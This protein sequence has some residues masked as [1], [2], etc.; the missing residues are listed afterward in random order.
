MPC[1]S[2]APTFEEVVLYA[3]KQKLIGKVDIRK[4]YDFYDRSDFLYRGIPMDWKGKLQEWASKQRSPVKATPDVEAVLKA[5]RRAPEQN[6][7][8]R[9]P[10]G[11]TTTDA[12]EYLTWLEKEIMGGEH[13]G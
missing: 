13:C 2:F 10:E 12:K 7:L 8:F 5:N 11:K 6:R 1:D 9:M 3:D 4:F